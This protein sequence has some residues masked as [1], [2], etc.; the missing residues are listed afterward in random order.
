MSLWSRSMD[1]GRGCRKENRSEEARAPMD[2][3]AL[4]DLRI[5]ND[6]QLVVRLAGGLHDALTVLFERH[7]AL[8]FRIARRM[9]RDNGEAE[10]TVQQ[11]FF[12]M[13][14][15]IKQF[16][17]EKGV[18]KTWMLQFA[19]HRT[20][21]RKQQLQSQHVFEW[22]DLDEVLPQLFSA[23]GRA[24]QMSTPEL[25]RLVQQLLSTLKPGQQQAIRL[26]F[27]EGLTA[28]EIAARTGE[29]VTSVRHNLYRGLA[30]LRTTLL[31]E[32]TE[33]SKATEKSERVKEET[34]V[35]YP[36]PL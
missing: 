1:E 12:D 31:E 22:R 35:P 8:V 3:A 16:D 10:E 29:S 2:S 26:T 7:S 5:L 17:P 20:F 15:A 13:Y 30:K 18:F 36:R 28:E 24:L 27:Y 21:N 25:V 32:R 23:T 33:R 34:F 6:E 4:A 9:L 19:F 11:V 14:R